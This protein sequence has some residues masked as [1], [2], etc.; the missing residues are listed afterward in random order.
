MAINWE[1]TLN[2]YLSVFF[3]FG[4]GFGLFTY[5]H[6]HLFSEGPNKVESTPGGP[7]LASRV[8]WIMV[9]TFLWPIMLL[10]GLNSALILA[11]RKRQPVSAQR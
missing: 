6:R 8:L 1:I 7:T 3:V 5:S 2:L 9:C 10:S 11:E 4:A